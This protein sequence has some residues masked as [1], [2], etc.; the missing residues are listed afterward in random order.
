[1]SL[2]TWIDPKIT[3][4]NI[5]TLAVMIVGFFIWGARLEARVDD[6]GKTI[7]RLETS[8]IAM[9]AKIEASRELASGRQEAVLTRLARME[10]ILERLEKNGRP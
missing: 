5:L 3:A 8:D 2:P 6:Y 9:N 10:A 7:A 1:V 4:G